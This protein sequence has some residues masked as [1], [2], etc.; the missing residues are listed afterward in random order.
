[1]NIYTVDFEF[2]GI[3]AQ[4]TVRATSIM[5]ALFKTLEAYELSDKEVNNVKI[6]Y[7]GRA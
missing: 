1:M 7:E 2:Y 4:N 5:E 3:K 6:R